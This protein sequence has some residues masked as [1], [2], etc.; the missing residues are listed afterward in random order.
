LEVNLFTGYGT[1][2]GKM[3]R[4]STQKLRPI[5]TTC[6]AQTKL[7]NE[8]IPPSPITG[9]VGHAGKWSATL[10]RKLFPTATGEYE[11]RGIDCQEKYQE[12]E[13]ISEEERKQQQTGK[14]RRQLELPGRQAM[15][16]RRSRSDMV[17]SMCIMDKWIEYERNREVGAGG[18]RHAP[19]A[20]PESICNLSTLNLENKGKLLS[21]HDVQALMTN[22]GNANGNAVCRVESG[23]IMRMPVDNNAAKPEKK[24][25]MGGFF[26]KL[27]RAVLKPRNVYSDGDQYQYQNGKMGKE[28]KKSFSSDNKE[29]VNMNP[30]PA[31][32]NFGLRD[33]KR[34]KSEGGS[35]K[36]SRFFQRGGLYRSSKMKK[37]NAAVKE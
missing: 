28:R 9:N 31:E 19:M 6:T 10:H 33:S 36:V 15:G 17:D 2:T 3:T 26:S 11:E 4:S 7:G 14:S 27:G 5:K 34:Y 29:N 22:G 30:M 8:G 16:H 18:E 1:S 12:R 13:I 21:K 35:N 23:P 20:E 24:S 37:K 32:G 25:S